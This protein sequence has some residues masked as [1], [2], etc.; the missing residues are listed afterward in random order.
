MNRSKLPIGHRIARAVC[1]LVVLAG[2]YVAVSF[3]V[4]HRVGP[5][6]LTAGLDLVHWARGL[7]H[8]GGGA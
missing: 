2:L 4:A 3:L 7:L 5:A 8:Q 6:A 1:G